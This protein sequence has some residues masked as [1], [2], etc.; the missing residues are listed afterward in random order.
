MSSKPTS[1]Q[2]S[3]KPSSAPSTVDSSIEGVRAEIFKLVN[4]ERAKKGLPAYKY[5]KTLEK[6]AQKYS[7]HM[8]ADNCFSHTCGSTLK[9]RMHE[10]GYYQPGKS[11]SYGENIA[12]GQ[13]TAAQVMRDWMNSP[14]HRD[15]IL[16]S[17]YL[18]IGIGQSGTFWAQ[19][20]GAVR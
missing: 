6:S 18:E 14:S 9:E 2:S 15:A 13:T 3:E 8:R 4:A 17:R 19:H 5:N 11:S 1:S 16:S 20:F 7:E 12:R 10:S